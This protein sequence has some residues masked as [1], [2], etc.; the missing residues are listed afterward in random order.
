[1]KPKAVTGDGVRR[2]IVLVIYPVIKC[3]AKSTYALVLAWG[4]RAQSITLGRQSGR[5]MRRLDTQ[6]IVGK[7]DPFLILF[8]GTPVHRTVQLTTTVGG[9]LT[10]INLI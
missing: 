2:K 9:L 7:R 1:M 4:L 10:S 8:H 6:F 3:R 5:S